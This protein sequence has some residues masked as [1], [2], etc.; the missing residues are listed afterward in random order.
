M[1][2]RPVRILCITDP[3]THP[4]F[5]TTVELYR[6]LPADPRFELFHLDAD[7]VGE[8]LAC[9]VVPVPRPISYDAFRRL[10]QAASGTAALPDFDLVWLRA[11]RPHPPGLLD[12]LAAMEGRVRFLPRP[13][14]QR[15]ADTRV[16]CRAVASR[17]MAPGVVTDAVA[18]AAAFVREHRRV[19]A[20]RD[21]TYAGRGVARIGQ[22]GD[23]WVLEPSLGAPARYSV[24]EELLA[25]LLAA[26]AGQ[27]EFVQYLDRVGEGD[28]R[29]MVVE[30]EVYG[31]FLRRAADGGWINNQTAGGTIHPATVLRE[32]AGIIEATWRAWHDR[33]LDL[34]GYDFLTGDDGRPVLSEVNAGNVGGFGAIEQTGGGATYPRLLDW[35]YRQATPGQ[36]GV[37]FPALG[38]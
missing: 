36:G 37:A 10:S 33:G 26:G 30:G 1:T 13:S 15:D 6:L 11:D 14:G 21:R 23:G 34:L 3:G 32:E 4:V 22:D 20:K 19:V 31:A 35:V 2:R 12:R 9:S 38:S 5:D 24:V 25:G 7:R 8:G 28:K 17:F 18:V 29:V 16:F 27:M